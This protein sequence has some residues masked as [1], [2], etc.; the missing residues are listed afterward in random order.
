MNAKRPAK[1]LARVLRQC[2]SAISAIVPGATVTLYGSATRGEWSRESDLD[3]LILTDRPLTREEDSRLGDAL[4]AL[5]L[6]HGVVFSERVVSREEWD[7]TLLR[8][9][10]LRENIQR[11]GIPI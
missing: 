6:E 10:P 1:A 4:Y 11:E 2:K 7:G 5:E 8:G 9:S 3:V